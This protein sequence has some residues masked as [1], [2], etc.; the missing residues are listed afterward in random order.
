MPGPA[1]DESFLRTVEQHATKRVPLAAPADSA[2]EIRER[3]LGGSFD[4]VDEIAVLDRGRLVGLLAMRRLLESPAAAVVADLMDAS[5]AVL[6]PGASR[7]AVA[8]EMVHRRQ[9]SV[10]VTGEDGAFLGQIP[11]DALLGQLL[12][13]HDADLARLG[14]YLAGTRR[15]RRAA[16]EPIVR[17]LWHRMPWL[18][19]GLA[20][21][22]ASAVIVG[23][24]EQELGKN[25]LLAF[26]LPAIVYMADAVGT[27]T[28]TV[29]IR[30]FS[31]ELDLS[32]VIRREIA[33][34]VLIGL[35]IG[36]VFYPFALIGW[37]DGDVALAVGLALFA[38][39][40]IATSVATVL[41]RLLQRLG[42]DPAFGSGPL[43]TIVQDL[44][45]IA[46]YLAIAVPIAT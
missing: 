1:V 46:V 3:V 28:E 29:L 13:A 18:I 39:C 24:F 45:S 25:V 12:Q 6:T 41:P 4:L 15:A 21:A 8:W 40:S 7:E 31:A 5:P 22:M 23:A 20:G 33:S 34:G 44:L 32:K 36:A 16:E 30:G 14:G 10:A 43:A 2:G 9:S 19:V 35:L 42:A 26:F 11:P 27:Q 38:S 17:R 37:G